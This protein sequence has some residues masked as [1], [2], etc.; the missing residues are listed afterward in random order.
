MSEGISRKDKQAGCLSVTM[1]IIGFFALTLS[2]VSHDRW[3]IPYNIALFLGMA[4]PLIFPL[5]AIVLIRHVSKLGA[6]LML[7]SVIALIL[8]IAGV[9]VFLADKQGN[10]EL[11]EGLAVELVGSVFTAIAIVLIEQSISKFM[12]DDD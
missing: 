3:G 6:G 2:L 5:L 10:P 11:A 1:L 9:W 4:A 7:V 8:M 12:Q